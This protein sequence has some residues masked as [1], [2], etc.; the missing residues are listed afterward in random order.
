MPIDYEAIREEYIK[1]YPSIGEWGPTLLAN[2]YSDQTHFIYELLQNAEDAEASEV[3]FRLY[4]D[5]L[6]FEHNGRPFNEADVRGICGVVVGTKKEDLTKIGRFGI[7]FKSVYAHTRS[8]EIHSE[9]EHFAIDNYVQPRSTCPRSSVLGTLFV[10]PFNHEE[11]DPDESFNEISKRLKD[12]GTDTLLFLKN[13]KSISYKIGEN[14]KGSYRRETSPLETNFVKKI[15]VIGQ[16]NQHEEHEHWLVFEKDV[17]RLASSIPEGGRLIVE[18][19]FLYA[20]SDSQ[21]SPKFQH[22]PKSNLVVYFPT[23]KETHLGFL[24]QGPYRTTPARDNIPQSNA[25]NIALAEQTGDLVVEALRWLQ[26][27]NWLTVKILMAMP[28]QFHRVPPLFYPVYYKVLSAIKDEDLI[29]AYGG[30]YVSGKN[31]KLAGSRELRNLLDNARLRQFCNTDDQLR[32]VSDEIT[33]DRTPLSRQYLREQVDVKEIDTEK[34]AGRIGEGF[35][36][37]QSDV[38]MREFYEFASGFGKYSPIIRSLKNKPIIR[39]QDDDRHVVPSANVY[40][41]TEHDS[42][43][44]TVKTEVCKS[45]KS[46]KA[47]EFLRNLGL[48]KPDIV[49]EVT[50]LI[51]P[52]YNRGEVNSADPAHWQHVETI[53]KAL[54]IILRLYEWDK[55]RTGFIDYLK[56]VPFLLATNVLATNVE[57]VAEFCC[58]EEMIYFR[59][60]ELEMY[61]K[62][63]PNV[64]FLVSGYEDYA[65]DFKEIGV[66]SQVRNTHIDPDNQGTI[67]LPRR[68]P[69][70]YG[71]KS[72]PY[73]RGLAGFDPNCEIDG[74]ELALKHPKVERAKFIWEC[75]LR[76]NW[77]SGDVES[78]TRKSFVR[79]ED[80][81]DKDYKDHQ[82]SKMGKLVRE[83]PWLPNNEGGFAVPSEI[84]LDELPDGFIKDKQL[85]DKLGMKISYETYLDNAPEEVKQHFEQRLKKAD[86]YEELER[87]CPEKLAKLIEEA[88]T[89][90]TNEDNS[91][92]GSVDSPE[93]LRGTGNVSSG[94]RTVRQSGGTHINNGSQLERHDIEKAA[95]VAVMQKEKD[96]GNTPCD[97]SNRRNLGHDIES[98]TPE[99]GSRFIEVKGHSSD[100]GSVKLTR[101]E[102][103]C[104]L[105][106]PQFILA[107]VKVVNG[108]PES[109]RYLPGKSWLESV[110]FNLRTLLECSQDPS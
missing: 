98:H 88:A 80:E 89:E 71:S 51:L 90:Q 23:E 5:R 96:L 22:P 55:K 73:R 33:P 45:D 32:W 10:F 4:Q 64:W 65:E 3:N 19:A 26:K 67:T 61:F 101:N 12:L 78:C 110:S 105:N 43:F 60:P 95:M 49:D 74:L 41:P 38:W 99:G 70:S 24:V 31:A 59:S 66:T 72:D 14:D 104:A 81:D 6:E 63:N 83:K 21:G 50:K 9:G 42:Q 52:K 35:L 62:G 25:F 39:L 37:C 106:N 75:L 92:P 11:K 79:N 57:D 107:L 16:S 40:L 100:D 91:V 47:M 17:T 69:D 34:F 103:R 93:H 108:R 85:A 97:V 53:V 18:I 54:R 44:H 86:R 58:P 2:K 46:D 48:K 109:P 77:I 36:E 84:T 15:A 56:R 8:P 7:G 20:D 29:P 102:V 27:K 68:C 76:P 1:K 87:K 94:S 13:I 82:V 30:G 28:L